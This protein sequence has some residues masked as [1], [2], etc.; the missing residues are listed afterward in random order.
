MK[1][2]FALYKNYR[3]F[4]FFIW[5]SIIL[6]LIGTIFLIPVLFDY[7]TTGLVPKMPSFITCMFFYI[8]SIQ[9]FFCGLILDSI[10]KKNKQDF[11]INYTQCSDNFK[12]LKR[13]EK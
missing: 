6:F 5:L 12:N 11:E 2:I 4:S 7:F 13:G 9:S 10:S 3:P 8:C 1:T